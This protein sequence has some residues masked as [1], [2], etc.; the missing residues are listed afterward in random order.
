[1]GNRVLTVQNLTHGYN[2]RT[3]FR[4]ANLDVEK[5]ERIAIIGP[6]GAGAPIGSEQALLSRS[7]LP[8]P[9]TLHPPLPLAPAVGPRPGPGLGRP[10][11]THST[12]PTPNPD[13]D[14]P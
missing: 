3:L 9:F 7:S 6:N 8:P 1:M 11:S 13:P 14:D 2:G 5:G 12:R 4:N 10:G